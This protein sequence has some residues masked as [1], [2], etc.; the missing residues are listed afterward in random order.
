MR[1]PF[2]ISIFLCATIL[3]QCANPVTPTGGNKD[4]S[5]P[6]LIFTEP[7]DKRTNVKP[8]MVV[9][10]FDEN[11]QVSNIKE[12]LVISPSI[13]TKPIITTGKNYVNVTIE[14]NSLS[15]NTTYSIQLNDCIKDLNE[16]N[17]GNYNPLLFST[18]KK[19]DTF[20]IVGKYLFVEEPKTQKIKVQTYG[21]NTYKSIPNKAR[22]FRIPGLPQDSIWVIAFND[23]N[24]DEQWNKGEE[25][26]VSF[27]S[28]TDTTSILLY[29]T[30]KEKIGVVRYSNNRYGFYGKYLPTNL[31]NK[32]IRYKDTLIGDSAAVFSIV[33][34]LDTSTFLVSKKP[35]NKKDLFLYFWKK[36]AFLKDSM[37][38]IYFVANRSI[39][40]ANT[41]TIEYITKDNILNKAA[42]SAEEWNILKIKFTNN[43]TGKIRIPFD[44]YMD[45]GKQLKDTL[46]TS[47]P[48]YT[49]LNIINKEKFEIFISITHKNTGEVYNGYILPNQKINLWVLSGDYNISYYR[50]SNKNMLLDGP[51]LDESNK[52]M[53][54]YYKK[55]PILKIKENIGVDLDIKG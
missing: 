51:S 3:W 48:V 24:G 40:T 46:Q 25:V 55:L 35:E 15:D 42:L 9:F 54:E 4:V 33:K 1:N 14:D 37:Q 50:D 53:G 26:G 28:T 30:A 52:F 2:Y 21:P 27:A 16:G 34:T 36:P 32:T 31:D 12:Q 45:E 23:L 47:I 39:F 43:Q 20:N 49:S 17:Q 8:K 10:K 6:K 13:K 5:P 41:K 7:A 38:E 18:G 11:I 22:L 29:N 19:L 44:F